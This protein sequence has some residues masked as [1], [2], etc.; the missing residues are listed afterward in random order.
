MEEARFSH[1]A[2]LLPNCLILVTGG[3][4][5]TAELH[6]FGA[7]TF[8]PEGAM[9]T[10]RSAH[11][12]TLLLN[13]KALVAAGGSFSPF[14]RQSC[15]SDPCFWGLEAPARDRSTDMNTRAG[16]YFGKERTFPKRHFDALTALSV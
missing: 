8:K 6:D 12:A 11:S 4:D 16:S 13:G 3:N 14:P 1:A 10:G 9:E 7:G 15:T 5:S 2:T